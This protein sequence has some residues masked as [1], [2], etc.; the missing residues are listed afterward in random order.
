[1]VV[2]CALHQPCLKRYV[3]LSSFGGGLGSRV[4]SGTRPVWW[5]LLHDICSYSTLGGGTMYKKAN[6]DTWKA[7]FFFLNEENPATPNLSQTLQIFLN[8]K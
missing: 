3:D 7:F 8:G 5:R 4:L 1:M 6:L 2:E